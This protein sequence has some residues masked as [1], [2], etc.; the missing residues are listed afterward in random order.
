VRL[1]AGAVTQTGPAEGTV[2]VGELA[3]PAADSGG[4]E[5]EARFYY[6]GTDGV[7][8][9]EAVVWAVPVA[10]GGG[11]PSPSSA[12]SAAGREGEAAG[13]WGLGRDQPPK[14]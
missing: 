2:D 5:V 1:A 9:I 13:V 4:V 8:R 14:R 7:C 6:C 3:L 11:T 10:A 12:P